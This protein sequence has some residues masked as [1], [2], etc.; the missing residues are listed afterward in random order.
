MVLSIRSADMILFNKRDPEKDRFYL[1]AGMG[2][3]AARRKR[4]IFL[5]WSV[6]A[7]ILVSLVFAVSLYFFNSRR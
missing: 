5:A 6:L 7:G 3:K 2:G 4:N 1:F